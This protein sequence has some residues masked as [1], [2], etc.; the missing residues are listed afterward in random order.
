M[1]IERSA[2]PVTRV[3]FPFGCPFKIMKTKTVKIPRDFDKEF[4]LIKWSDNWADEMDLEG[5]AVMDTDEFAKWKENI[6][7][8]YTFYVGTNEEIDYSTKKELIDYSTKKELISNLEVQPLTPGEVKFFFDNFGEI[9]T[10]CKEWNGKDFEL[11][12]EYLVC[13]FGFFPGMEDRDEDE[14]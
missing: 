13:S 1:F 2:T 11:V 6:P 10:R 4:V 8:P 7:S 14:E 3:K 12:E 5:F 9:D